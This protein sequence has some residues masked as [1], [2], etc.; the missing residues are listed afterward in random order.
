MRTLLAAAIAAAAVAGSAA[1]IDTGSLS[2][3]VASCSTDEKGC[4]SATHDVI[5]S[6][7]S[8]GYGCIPKA[9]SSVEGGERLLDWLKGP[10]RS[11]A[12]YERMGLEDVMWAGVD[13]LWP[14]RR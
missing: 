4:K 5:A 13:E 2:A 3:F 14:C 9:V 1:A 12:K 11:V 8:A 7:K 10:A 6:A